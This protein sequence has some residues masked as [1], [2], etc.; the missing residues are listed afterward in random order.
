MC[1]LESRFLT[2]AQ[3][4]PDA[5]SFSWTFLS[6]LKPVEVQY[7][8]A[9]SLHLKISKCWHELGDNEN[10]KMDLRTRLMEQLVS[11]MTSSGSRVV[12]TRV[13]VA[14]AAFAVHTVTNIWQ[15]AIHDLIQNLSV[16]KLGPQIGEAKIVHTLLELLTTVPEEFHSIPMLPADK[17]LTRTSLLKSVDQVFSY[18]QTILMQDA[19][20]DSTGSMM[21]LQQTAIRCFSNWSQHLGCLV[22]CPAGDVILDLCLQKLSNEDLV[23]HTVETVIAIFTH[24]ESHKFP[25]S[26]LNLIQKLVAAIPILD[27][28]IRED[29]MDHTF[30]LYSL[31]IQIA[32]T[33]SR[34]LLDIVSEKPEERET[35]CRLISVVVRCAGTPGFYPVDETCSEQSFNFFYILQDDIIASEQEKASEYLVLF[36][37]LYETLI[38]TLLA[39]VQYPSDHMYETEWNSE[40]KEAF[41][42]YRQDI[43]DTFMYC[44]NM[45][46]T[47]VMSSLRI[48]FERALTSLCSYA[49]SVQTVDPTTRPW[50]ALE[51]VLFAFSSVAENVSPNDEPCM[52]YVFQSVTS[53]PFAASDRLLATSME[54]VASYCE[55]IFHHPFILPR[56]LTLLLLGLRAHNPMTTAAATMALKD[57]TR[58]CQILMEPYA[59]SVLLACAEGISHESHLKSKEKVRLMCSIGQVLSLLPHDVM[60]SYLSQLLPPIISKLQSCVQEVNQ[61]RYFVAKNEAMHQLNLIGTIFSSIDLDVK[62][63]EGADSD[64][65]ED[66]DD[67]VPN[68]NNNNETDH[69]VH[70]LLPLF[71]QLMPLLAQVSAKWL[72]QED[73]IESLSECLK[74]AVLALLSDVRMIVDQVIQL[75]TQMYVSTSQPSLI[76]VIK[77]LIMLFACDEQVQPQLAACFSQFCFHTISVCHE[78]IR[79]RTNLIEYFYMSTASLLKKQPE[80]FACPSVDSHGLFRLATAALILP[81]RPTVKSAAAFLTEFISKSREHGNMQDIV[82]QEGESLV[83]QIYAVISGTQDSPRNV[84]EFTADIL[85]SLNY[86]YFDNLN[87]WL[88]LVAARDGFPS[89]RVTR[90]HKEHFT[91]LLLRERRN[92]RKVR[93]LVSEFTLICRG[94]VSA[95]YGMPAAKLLPM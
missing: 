19:S 72:A 23:S 50:Q 4:S 31:Y 24:P 18:L 93:D 59:S 10:A 34:L 86:K 89:A 77:Q 73:L 69:V 88:T 80:L 87:A 60:Q 15:T 6:S 85:L 35:I 40:D 16:E 41:R 94:L 30:A 25:N 2:L 90:E 14:L 68:R 56:V 39:K 75:I 32:E 44:Y 57:L 48:N 17:A 33:H 67:V 62:R 3:I 81:E 71:Q 64:M 54:T 28:T 47:T 5:W 76:D 27:Q 37:P 29:R 70:P 83:T 13:T 12:Q 22:I 8:G 38:Q 45:L 49:S 66:S 84:V 91:R 1:L 92:K 63:S 61:D 46:R 65:N 51:A 11:L 36:K 20:S 82:K 26:V 53:I 9:S 21:E 55:W 74:K 58:E 7:F 95:P 43:G 79:D 52:D 42:C 78:Q